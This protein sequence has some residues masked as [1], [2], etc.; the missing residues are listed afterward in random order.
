MIGKRIW[1]HGQASKG[2]GMVTLLELKKATHDNTLRARSVEAIIHSGRFGRLWLE[3][4]DIQ[5]QAAELAVW[6]GSTTKL[7]TWMRDHTGLELGERSLT[8]LKAC[9]KKLRVK[10]YSRLAKWELINAIEVK[11]SVNEQ[12]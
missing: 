9:A 11:E 12:E 10:N 4:T 8:W 1:T 6:Q 2:I 5:K 7:T 3:S